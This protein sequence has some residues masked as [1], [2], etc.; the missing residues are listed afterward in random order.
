M[1]TAFFA[2]LASFLVAA[3]ALPVDVVPQGAPPWKRAVIHPEGAPPWRRTVIHSDSDQGWKRAT[4]VS[5]SDQG[6]PP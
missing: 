4:I 1:R 6:A 3:A 5:D 2:L